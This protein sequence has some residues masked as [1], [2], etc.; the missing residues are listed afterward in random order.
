MASFQHKISCFLLLLFATAAFS[1][2][3]DSTKS[4]RKSMFADIQELTSSDYLAS[5]ERA[6][7]TMNIVK[8]K[9]ELHRNILFIFQEISDTNSQISLITQNIKDASNTNV[10]N[11]R[12]YQKVL[13]ELQEQLDSYE[14]KLNSETEKNV[15]L[16][17]QLRTVIKDTVFR[18]L[19]RDSILRKPFQDELKTLKAKFFATDSAFKA[20]LKILNTHKIQ[21]TE[22][23]IIVA[24][25]L[26]LVED[27]LDK[28]GVSMFRSECPNIWNSDIS[29]KDQSVS[30]FIAEKFS[31]ETKA[32]G[33]YFNHSLRSTILLILVMGLLFW[34]IRYNL[35]YIRK[36]DKFE[37]LN[38][39]K[40]SYLNR[41][42]LLPVL[43]IGLNIAIAMHLYA[44]ALYIEFLHLLL[45]ASL[46]FLFVKKWKAKVF[47]RWMLLVAVFAG[48]CFIDLFLKITLLQRCIFLFAN[49]VSIRFGLVHLKHIKEEM[50]VKGFF[51]LANVLFIGFNG[52]AILFNIF[53]RVSLAYT[54]SLTAIIALTQIIALSVLLKIILEM[55]TLQI[56]TIRLKR[57]ITKLFDFDKLVTNAQRPFV[58]LVIYLWVV[59][60][61]SNLNLSETLTRVSDFIFN[62]KNTIGSFQF[63]IGGIILFLAIIWIAHLLQKFVAYF[64]GEIDQENEEN[65]N[66]RQH[67]KL[68]ITRLVLLVVG[69][70]LAISASGMPIDKITIILGALGV[71][72]GLGLQSIV[73][74]FVSGVILIFERPIQIGDVIE[75]GS[76][77]GRVTE[78]GL[79]TTKIDTS[80]GAEVIVP[81]GNI[82]SQPIV[83]WTN[84]NNYR[85]TKLS[86]TLTGEISQEEIL[87]T[88]TTA[89]NSL[90]E[91]IP[92]MEHQVFFESIGVD[93]Y[94]MKVKF[95]CNIYRKDQTLSEAKIGLFESFKKRGIEMEDK[96]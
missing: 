94:T 16:K 68:L 59:V 21:N 86:F 58:L 36:V 79:R 28:S 54:L 51:S 60:I 9:G 52:L 10:R 62:R 39:F 12:M 92:D 84:S 42:V 1:Q 81:N 96:S 14:T 3:P 31:V 40:F 67:S 77:S 87:Q 32:F 26:V 91:P 35:T 89:L 13:L 90:P 71:G 49:V 4:K 78:I 22:Q 63:T 7:E 38:E 6:N 56:Y 55:L 50:Y 23:K 18:K 11:Q 33:Y 43:V 57:G 64:F 95:W 69:Y 45:L 17:K 8:N 88:I 74:N 29:L 72:V 30:S 70:L 5:I 27:R 75:T 46:S 93:K 41:G 44:P 61:A 37:T 85:L 76:Q 65:I 24:E 66:K 48:F 47:R 83:N 73:N 19:V 2:T 82:L 25:A 80:D 15:T 34:W 53:G 20:N